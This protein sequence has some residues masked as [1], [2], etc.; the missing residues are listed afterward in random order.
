MADTMQ[1]VITLRK[2]VPDQ[3]AARVIYDLVKEKMADR[4]DVILSGH[5]SNHFDL[6]AQP[7]G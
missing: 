1:I 3:A 5:C 2:E 7:P 6:D 4:P